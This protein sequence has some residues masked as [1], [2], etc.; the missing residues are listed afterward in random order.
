LHIF[1]FESGEAVLAS[2]QTGAVFHLIFLDVEMKELSGIGTAKRIKE[3]DKNVI[4][5]FVTNHQKYVPDAFTVNAFQF[6]TKPLKQELFNAEFAR[7]LDAHQKARFQYQISFKDR[8]VVLEVGDIFYIETHNRR[9]RAFTREK[10]YEFLGSIGAEEKK[11]GKYDFMRCHQGYLVNMKHISE[12]CKNEFVLV[13][14]AVVPIS[15]QL[16]SEALNRFN[17]FVSGGL[18]S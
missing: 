2:Y 15:K 7:A 11:L 17:M 12:I 14:G 13:N 16:K 6:L 8:T 10:S 1:Q 3:R 5:I 18:I 9:L 4:F